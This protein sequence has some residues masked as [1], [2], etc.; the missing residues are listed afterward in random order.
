MSTVSEFGCLPEA[1]IWFEN[2]SVVRPGL[3]TGLGCRGS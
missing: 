2:W 1:S 3:K